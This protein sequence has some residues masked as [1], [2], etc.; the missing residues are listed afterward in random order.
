M[1]AQAPGGSSLYSL[2]DFPSTLFA[3][4]LVERSGLGEFDYVALNKKLKGKNISITPF[5]NPIANGFYG[6]STPK[7][8]ETMLQLLYLYFDAPRFD[9]TAF[10]AVISET[11]NQLKFITGNPLFVFIDTLNKTLNQNDPRSIAI[12]SE[13][14]INNATYKQALDIYK[15]RFG[16]AS[17]LIFTFV[18]NIKED[19]ILPLFEKYLGSLPTSDKKE[20]FKNVYYGFPDETKEVNIYV[21]MD[22]KSSVAIALDN[23]Y[24]WNTKTNL[25]LDIFK[26]ILQIKLYEIIREKW[27]ELTRLLFNFSTLNILKPLILL[28]YILI[29]ILKKQKKSVKQFLV[30]ITNC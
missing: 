3:V 10:Q 20:I 19:T 25:C 30:F 15:D 23:E 14:F 24:E 7:D 21:G 1:T 22:N 29:A 16:N 11:K 6:S 4:A 2:Y 5:I 26:E 18:G 13:T 8:I 28:S 27:E 17:N 12:P 9:E